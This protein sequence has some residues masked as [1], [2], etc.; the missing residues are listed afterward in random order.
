MSLRIGSFVSKVN[1][2]IT[3]AFSTL[4]RNQFKQI[5]AQGAPA[6]PRPRLHMDAK[7]PMQAH[8]VRH[9]SGFNKQQFSTRTSLIQ[10][11][12][13]GKNHEFPFL[14]VDTNLEKTSPKSIAL[15][16]SEI[17]LEDEREER[18][19]M[20]V[21]ASPMPREEETEVSPTHLL[22]EE[23]VSNGVTLARP[24]HS[25]SH[26]LAEIMADAAKNA[27][28]PNSKRRDTMMPFGL[29]SALDHDD[30]TGAGG[31]GV[32]YSHR[33]LTPMN[34]RLADMAKASYF[35]KLE[36]F[37]AEQKIKKA[38]EKEARRIA[39]LKEKENVVPVMVVKQGDA[40]S[41][42]DAIADMFG[43]MFPTAS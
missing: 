35:V 20:S 13:F 9:L 39:A 2:H 5:L 3:H 14:R 27:S 22:N 21:T 23:N 31:F 42:F 40:P 10:V 17:S 41:G 43:G 37:A 30:A 26:P 24:N 4:K 16:V 15:P 19:S 8:H 7:S 18:S 25:S 32:A 29:N 1:F 12:V 34:T 6:V 38:A 28:K 11:P 33:P 36:Q